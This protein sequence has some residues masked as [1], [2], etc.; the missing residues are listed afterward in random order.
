MK[1]IVNFLPFQGVNI[2]LLPTDIIILIF[3]R[4]N[5]DDVMTCAYISPQSQAAAEHYYNRYFKS[6]YLNQS[7]LLSLSNSTHRCNLNFAEKML[8]NIGRHIKSLS[9]DYTTFCLSTVQPLCKLIQIHCTNLE[10]ANIICF[11]NVQITI[12]AVDS[13][14]RLEAVNCWFKASNIVSRDLKSLMYSNQTT[15]CV[16]HLSTLLRQFPDIID[17]NVDAN[18]ISNQNF[19]DIASL[20]RLEILCVE[21][22]RPE[23]LFEMVM[24]GNCDVNEFV[25]MLLRT[26]NLK[27]FQLVTPFFKKL[28]DAT[29]DTHIRALR[30][31]T[32]VSLVA[33]AFS[34]LEPRYTIISQDLWRFGFMEVA[35]FWEL[36]DDLG[37]L[38]AL[39]A[40]I[41][42]EGSEN[43]VC[44]ER[45][46]QLEVLRLSLVDLKVS[47]TNRVDDVLWSLHSGANRWT[48][49]LKE[50]G[51]N[52]NYTTPVGKD[53]LPTI[54]AFVRINS[55]LTLLTIVNCTDELIATKEQVE[56]ERP[57]L[58][59]RFE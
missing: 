29:V 14:K 44:L 48:C 43:M 49:R 46:V 26:E 17:L 13:L 42:F 9:V 57:G 4:L 24:L 12:P 15:G 41:T 8:R 6:L 38:N 23:H 58:L 40:T 7:S 53:I 19:K 2:E 47:Q 18:I 22:V 35:D 31:R 59:V 20:K 37:E 11:S 54:L 34:D 3:D 36:R 1:S 10:E 33:T 30:Q 32:N 28:S 16:K 56:K 25:K 5:L 27:E 51:L 45:M 21:M 50:L 55:L 52:A 39:R